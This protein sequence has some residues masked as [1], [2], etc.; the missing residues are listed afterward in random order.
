MAF[1]FQILEL[2]IMFL[3]I[4]MYYGKNGNIIDK[5][6]LFKWILVVGYVMQMLYILAFVSIRVSNS[7]LVFAKLYFVSVVILS[8]LIGGYY[9]VNILKEKYKNQSEVYEEK[10]RICKMIGIGISTLAV[11]LIFSAKVRILDDIIRLNVD[12]VSVF[13]EISLLLQL[14]MLFSFYQ[15]LEVKKALNLLVILIIEF[16]VLGSHFYFNYLSIFNSGMVFIILYL[17]MTLENPDVIEN[18]ILRIERDNAINNNI[19]KS[20]F[21]KNISHEIRIPI[22]TIDGFSQVIMDSDNMG[23]IKDDVRDIRVASRD[24]IDIINGK[25]KVNK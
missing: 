9:I 5:K 18:K 16:V 12:Y 17:Y 6:S 23:E 10:T 25:I 7:Y 8:L 13:M 21:L 11:I 22:N 2:F 1:Q 15:K 3:L 24:L 4:V 14:L 19:D 20:A